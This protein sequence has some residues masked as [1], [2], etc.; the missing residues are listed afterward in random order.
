MDNSGDPQAKISSQENNSSTWVSTLEL[1]EWYHFLITHC[2]P[3]CGVIW[4]NLTFGQTSQ[5]GCF[6]TEV[7]NIEKFH[8]GKK[9]YLW[10]HL[11]RRYEHFHKKKEIFDL[12]I[13][14]PRMASQ[15]TLKSQTILSAYAFFLG[16]D[17]SSH[18][19]PKGFHDQKVKN[20]D[21]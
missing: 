11:T 13:F 6:T 4:P 7:I 21:S 8:S 14:A 5:I 16:A 15:D 10:S 12:E 17:P 9:T 18:Q 2:L 19:I 3:F 1:L 20:H